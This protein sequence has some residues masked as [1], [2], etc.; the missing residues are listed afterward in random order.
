[1]SRATRI[2]LFLESLEPSVELPQ[3]QT[4]KTYLRKLESDIGRTQKFVDRAE[5]AVSLLQEYKDGL[6][7]ERPDK[8]SSDWT[9]DT[10]RKAH[11]LA[12]YEVYKQLPYMA[13][14]NDLIG[15]ATAATLTAKAVKDQIR[16]SDALSDENEALKDE[17]ERLKTILVSY[18]EVN[19]LILERAQ[20]HPQR[21]EKLH[22]QTEALKLQFA[23][24]QKSCSLA[25]KA[26]DE[27]KQLEETLL[28]HQRRL[29]VKLHAMMDWENTIVADEETF[30]RNISQSS[31]F[32]KELVTRLLDTDDP[33]NTVE[34][35]TPEEHLAKLMV[36]HGLL[37][38]RKGDVFDVSLR[39]YSK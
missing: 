1:M 24:T 22:E 27:A 34:A 12:L 9:E 10:E 29:I 17:I 18:R 15:I 37:K 16:A 28:S 3:L 30:R 39:D 20:E 8:G 14:R 7:L 6:S 25:V 19:R 4:Q 5:A 26:C 21:M 13:P 2:R 11:L 36:Q 23:N 35:G 31:A 33:W 38:T 32:L